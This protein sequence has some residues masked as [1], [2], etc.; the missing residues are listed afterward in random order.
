M[1]LLHPHNSVRKDNRDYVGSHEQSCVVVMKSA[2]RRAEKL[3]LVAD[4][5]TM[6]SL[7]SLLHCLLI[8]TVNI[9]SISLPESPLTQS[10]KIDLLMLLNTLRSNTA[11]YGQPTAANM[12]FVFWDDTLAIVS[13]QAAN[14]C[15]NPRP[16]YQ[17]FLEYQSVYSSWE[18]PNIG[19]LISY[20]AS[21]TNVSIS[22]LPSLLQKAYFENGDVWSYSKYNASIK[23]SRHIMFEY[24]AWSKLRY[25]G[26]GYQICYNN[27]HN[28]QFATFYCT[29]F[30]TDLIYNNYPWISGEPCT[31]CEID[32]T[33]CWNGLCGYCM[34]SDYF[35]NG[36]N[37]TKKGDICVNLG[38]NYDKSTSSPTIQPSSASLMN[39]DEDKSPDINGVDENKNN[40]ILL[41]IVVWMFIFMCLCGLGILWFIK[42]KQNIDDN[43]MKSK[44][45]ADEFQ[46]D[47]SVCGNLD[48]HYSQ[49]DERL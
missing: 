21:T 33:E 30:Y 31:K 40:G 14:K 36:D 13:Q 12:N 41:Q 23:Q 5:K 44:L 7:I 37:S 9:V 19:G 10:D 28:K 15:N 38:I 49:L 24:L 16:D 20:R 32:K 48:Y 43:D 34:T 17:N 42:Y 45:I 8:T 27:D 47:H 46:H 39:I 1:N 6:V 3:R 26:C 4:S 18:Y 11:R 2:Q 29:L 22:I 35:I 25:F